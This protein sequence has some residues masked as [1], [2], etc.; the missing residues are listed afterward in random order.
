MPFKT[1]PYIPLTLF[2]PNPFKSYEIS[3]ETLRAFTLG[4]EN[5]RWPV[6]DAAVEL[7]PKKSGFWAVF[8][9]AVNHATGTGGLVVKTRNAVVEIPRLTSRE[10]FR[11][12][13]AGTHPAIR[14]D[15]EGP[16]KEAAELE[17]FKATPLR[18]FIVS[19]PAIPTAVYKQLEKRSLAVGPILQWKV[20]VGDMVKQGAVVAEYKVAA[21]KAIDGGKR[22][23]ATIT[24]PHT[25][26]IL[27][28]SNREHTDWEKPDI[29]EG[30]AGWKHNPSNLLF[31]FQY[32]ANDMDYQRVLKNNT[33]ELDGGLMLWTTD[34]Y[35]LVRYY[36]SAIY[37]EGGDNAWQG[38]Q[39]D[40]SHLVAAIHLLHKNGSRVEYIMENGQRRLFDLDRINAEFLAEQ[41]T[42][43][44]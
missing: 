17:A 22:P 29:R 27:S 8:G 31:S 25:G 19:V 40:P 30:V 13:V 10:A 21:V 16:L 15:I 1:R 36:E 39:Y 14:A 44:I 33:E 20:A 18:P 38:E 42:P 23:K 26:K 41:A 6:K 3:D 28:I 4:I 24:M 7:P 34:N 37:S 9:R 5:G 32:A 2:V 35:E 43:K 12:A 11:A